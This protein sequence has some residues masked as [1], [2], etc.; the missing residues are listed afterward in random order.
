MKGISANLDGP[1]E[2]WTCTVHVD[3]RD[4][5]LT[6]HSLGTKLVIS[7]TIWPEGMR[8]FQQMS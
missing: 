3:S 4:I 7:M 2:E 1:D 6:F 5:I 8:L